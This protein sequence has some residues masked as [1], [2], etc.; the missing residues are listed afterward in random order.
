MKNLGK[1]PFNQYL[2]EALWA[3]DGL[4]AGY[5]ALNLARLLTHA[6]RA[7]LAQ[8][9]KE[10]ATE[11]IARWRGRAVSAVFARDPLS[12]PSL[13]KVLDENSPGATDPQVPIFLAQG[14]R[15]E[16]V[17]VSVSAELEA[18]YCSLGA[19]VIRRVYGGADHDGVIDA[20]SKDVLAWMRD[21]IR[22]RPVPSS[23]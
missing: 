9:P 22:R 7:N 14:S 11:T 16:Q 18:R 12:I 2:G 5:P 13:V 6:A 21:R 1:A 15:D 4:D 10:C 20:A 3:V 19:I 23:C 17:P 8:V